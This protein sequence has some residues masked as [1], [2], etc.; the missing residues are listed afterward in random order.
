M[1]IIPPVLNLHVQPVGAPSEVMMTMT[2]STADL[3]TPRG[4]PNKTT[5]DTSSFILKESTHE[6]LNIRCCGNEFYNSEKVLHE[7]PTGTF[8]ET[9]TTTAVDPLDDDDD[10][11]FAVVHSQDDNEDRNNNQNESANF[12]TFLSE[13]EA[14]R[15]EFR[16][17]TTYA[18]AHS[19]AA[20]RITSSSI[21]E[22]LAQ[23]PPSS[24]KD[25]LLQLHRSV[26][27][28]EV[29]NKQFAQFVD[30]L[31]EAPCQPTVPSDTPNSDSTVPHHRPCPPPQLERTPRHV[32][33]EG[34]PPAPNPQSRPTPTCLRTLP[35]DQ[36]PRAC[37]TMTLDRLP[38]PTTVLKAP[39]PAPP[40]S[41]KPIPNWARPAVLPPAVSSPMEGVYGEPPLAPATT[42]KKN[43][44]V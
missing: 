44:P 2:T 35:I 36:S 30:S 8:K 16:N 25:S 17:S 18:L 37:G 5:S 10:D 31:D 11:A 20:D 9:H 33:M 7:F 29:V 15:A 40:N 42:G 14:F 4:S 32:L 13:W 12:S 28:L 21:D 27:A 19:S 22:S 34:P 39:P 41:Q 23:S 38:A 3:I 43:H 1:K 26:K 6:K 24:F